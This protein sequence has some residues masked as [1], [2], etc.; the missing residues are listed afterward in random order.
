VPYNNRLQRTVTGRRG[1]AAR[2]AFHCAHAARWTRG[3]AAAEPER[4][5]APV[6]FGGV[7][8]RLLGAAFTALIL[9]AG[10]ITVVPST[11]AEEGLNERLRAELLEMG[12][13][14]QQVRE[15]LVP[16]ASSLGSSGPPSPEFMALVAEQR[17][18]DEAN[19]RRLDEIVA[20]VGWP[21]KTLVGE[22]ASN[23]ARMLV[24]HS[25]LERQKRYLPILKAAASAGEATP[26]GVAMLEDRI[27]VNSG[28]TQLYGS[29]FEFGPDGQCSISPLEDPTKVDERRRAVGLAPM[30]DY[31]REIEQQLG[32]PCSMK[33]GAK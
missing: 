22:E 32:K 30:Q 14:D 11:R 18:V 27:R 12:R 21:G 2:A 4:Y 5:A 31:L 7:L 10:L 25:N 13:R 15:K 16:L 1:R 29:Q 24:Q 28:E 26:W 6:G 8:A 19:F 23:V 17:E 20:E 33:S 3:H 9:L